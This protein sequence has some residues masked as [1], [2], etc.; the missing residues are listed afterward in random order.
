MNDFSVT[1]GNRIHFRPCLEPF[2]YQPFDTIGVRIFDMPASIDSITYTFPAGYIPEFLPESVNTE[3]QC[4]KYRY[5][6]KPLDENSLL[7]IREL[8]I[9]KGIYEGDRARK[10]FAFLNS[11][12]EGDHQRLI[13]VR[14]GS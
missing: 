4:G 10:L 3:A 11:A 2:D 14:S 8:K 12:A 7:F 9:N 13:L 1:A 6:I 5:E